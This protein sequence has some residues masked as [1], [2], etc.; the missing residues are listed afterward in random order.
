[1]YTGRDSSTGLLRLLCRGTS[2]FE[3][4][5]RARDFLKTPRS[6]SRGTT[7]LGA[8][9][10]GRSSLTATPISVG[11]TPPGSGTTRISTYLTGMDNSRVFSDS[12][13]L[14]PE[15]R[16]SYEHL[17][18]QYPQTRTAQLVAQ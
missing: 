12:G 10:L 5:S 7:W 1:M 17:A 9:S 14:E 8:P 4:R 15:V 11:R 13:T 18:A 16:T 3:P 2:A 6:R